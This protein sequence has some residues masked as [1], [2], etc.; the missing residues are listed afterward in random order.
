MGKTSLGRSYQ[1]IDLSGQ[2]GQQYAYMAS[3]N[4]GMTYN[5]YTAMQTTNPVA[6]AQARAGEN[7]SLLSQIFTQEEINWVKE[8]ADSLGGQLDPDA[9]LSIVPEF[10]QRF[11]NHNISVIQQQLAA[12]GIVQTSDPQK[13][14]AYAFN[15]IA[16]NN[17]DLAN[18]QKTA[19]ANQPMSTKD[20]AKQDK[21]SGFIQGFSS[22]DNHGSS[23][24]AKIGGA[25]LETVTAGIVGDIGTDKGDS[26]AMQEYK[27]QVRA[28]GQRNPVIE[29]LLQH[30]GD[31]D[32]AKVVVHTGTGQ[33]VVSLKD[34]IKNHSQELSSGQARFAEGGEA[35]K[36][37]QDVVGVGGINATADWS[38]EAAKDKGNK[39]Q[40]LKDWQKAHPDAKTTAGQGS[41]TGA[42][43][44]V[45][46]DLSDAAK[47]LLRISAA[48]GIAGANG[49]GAPPLNSYNWNASR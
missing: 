1:D 27:S 20:A 15:L 42:N 39:G 8:K 35:G 34:A 44:R 43:G 37:V 25:F 12:Y 2:M 10:L 45:V 13:A 14:L 29:N 16:G 21:D 36:S 4:M 46:V 24:A 38:K 28:S 11:P 5:Q 33:R 9:A 48:T 47:Q 23:T 41:G 7:L 31:Q 30:V 17:G 19:K 6:A 3:S 32:K 40:S 49:E 26:Q 22:K 18:A